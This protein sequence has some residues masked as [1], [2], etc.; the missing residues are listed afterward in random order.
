[1]DVCGE[2]PSDLG[3]LNIGDGAT[4]IAS[5][6]GEFEVQ[7]AQPVG[8]SDLAQRQVVGQRSQRGVVHWDQRSG[9]VGG[10]NVDRPPDRVLVDLRPQLGFEVGR[11]RVRLE[12]G[13]DEAAEFRPR[14]AVRHRR[15]DGIPRRAQASPARCRRPRR[16]VWPPGSAGHTGPSAAERTRPEYDAP[17]RCVDCPVK[18][19]GGQGVPGERLAGSPGVGDQR[20]P[21]TRPPAASHLEPLHRRPVII[22]AARSDGMALPGRR[23]R[24]SRDR[25]PLCSSRDGA[26]QATTWDWARA[27]A[28]DVHQPGFVAGVSTFPASRPR[29]KSGC[30]PTQATSLVVGNRPAR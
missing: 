19:P 27:S 23:S 20:G 21:T 14:W 28:R 25:P 18:V 22:W 5:R 13:V 17:P 11:Q 1:M 29:R 2:Q 4:E 9:Q 12:H 15:R 24:S 3:E 10:R 26:H 16:R 8:Q 7:F 6:Q 30:P